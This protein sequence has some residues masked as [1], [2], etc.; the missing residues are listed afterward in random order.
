MMPET[1]IIVIVDNHADD[2]L[3]C[4]HGLA[5]HLQVDDRSILFDTG[6]G[7]ALTANAAALGIKLTD[8]GTLVLSHGHYDHTGGIPELTELNPDL[9]V[10]FHQDLFSK[11]YSIHPGQPV[12]DISLPEISSMALWR[13]PQKHLHRLRGPYKLLPQVW[14]TG[15]IPRRHDFEDTGGPFFLDRQGLRADAIADDMALWINTPQGLVIVLGCCHSGLISTVEYIQQIS[16]IRKIHGIIGGMHLLH[17]S[18]ERLEQTCDQLYKWSPDWLV[19]CHCTG[20]AAVAAIV[21]RLD[22]KVKSG[23]AGMAIKI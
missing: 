10:Y 19:P 3:S 23:Y 5:I 21:A 6:Q 18:P 1:E 14:I 4:E 11:R 17:A 15:E 9:E 20:D 16:G 8:I 22:K 12:K 2:G 13:L 7:S